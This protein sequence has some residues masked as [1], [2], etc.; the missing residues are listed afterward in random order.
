MSDN[1]YNELAEAAVYWMKQGYQ[2]RIEQNK[3]GISI[4]AIGPGDPDWEYDDEPTVL[5]DRCGHSISFFRT[6][7]DPLNEYTNLCSDCHELI[8]SGR[9]QCERCGDEIMY[10]YDVHELYGHEAW[11]VICS[12]CY[13]E[14]RLSDQ[15]EF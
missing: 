2:I 11:S 13:E 14:I 6:I 1:L 12:N 15:D 10:S 9:N 5:C 8:E 3:D 4:R 7:D